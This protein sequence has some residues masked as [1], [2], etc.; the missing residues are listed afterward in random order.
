MTICNN[1]R[2]A[3]SSVTSWCSIDGDFDYT[4]FWQSIVDFFKRPPGRTAQ[5]RVKRLLAWWTRC[6]LYT[7]SSP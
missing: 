4:L 6:I 2:F 7:L 1:L 5:Q 3:L